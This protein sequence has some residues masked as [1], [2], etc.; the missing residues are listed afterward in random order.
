[1]GAKL[2]DRIMEWKP[3]KAGIKLASEIR[4]PGFERLSVYDV[5]R[6]FIEGLQKGAVSTRAAAIAFR[7]FLSIFPALIVLLSLIPY[8]PIENFQEE[9]FSSI[10]S[11]FPG[12][13]FSLF[14]S[15]LNDL[16]HR[17]HA[18]VLSIGFILALFFASDTVNAIL[19]GFNGSYNLEKR[20]NPFILRLLSLVLLLGLTLI[21]VIAMGLITFS[22]FIFDYLQTTELVSAGI[23]I[24][25]LQV[26][27]WV[28]VILLIYSSV[29]VLYNV[30]DFNRSRWKLFS[31][32]AS[33]ATVFFILASI[34]F[35]W[36]VTN[37]S[38]YN[39]LYGSLGTFLVLLIWM[40]FNCM[41]LLLGF[42][43]NA[44]I[45][46]AKMMFNNAQTQ[47]P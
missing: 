12:D 4:P 21:L 11:F 34:G 38:Q 25:A 45:S 15:T 16:I 42:E 27:K 10:R 40:N 47:E 18:T 23:V 43:L 24:F 33:F 41:I 3:V 5:A 46:R 36:F 35:A 29:S 17:T 28:I 8:I 14:E 26:A 37:F 20:R 30:G 31:A 6:Y 19:I 22:E 1:M 32:G 39:K 9:L 2:M 7:L 44:S 13:T